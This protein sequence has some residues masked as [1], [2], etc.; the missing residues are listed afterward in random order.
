MPVV[1][2][3]RLSLKINFK[4]AGWTEGYWLVAS[5]FSE[6]LTKG[7]AIAQYRTAFFGA[8]VELVFAS[9]QQQN[10]SKQAVSCDLDFP[11]GPHPQVPKAVESPDNPFVAVQQR[12]ETSSGS[13]INRM[14]RGVPD[15]AI[16]GFN[17]GQKDIWRPLP[18]GANIASPTGNANLE[19]IQRSFWNYLLLNSPHSKKTAPNTYD[20]TPY[21]RIIPIRVSRHQ[22]GRPFGQFRGRSPSN[23]IT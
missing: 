13:W 14:Y 19:S 11:L 21:V 20:Q 12:F 1:N 7:V 9:I 18:P 16:Q 23:S 8:G 6:A 22:T 3:F 10:P 17:I 4:T 15:N 5:N 2:P